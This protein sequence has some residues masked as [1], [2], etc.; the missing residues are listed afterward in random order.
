MLKARLP[1][2]SIKTLNELYLQKKENRNE[3]II[4]LKEHL[5]SREPKQIANESRAAFDEI[6]K[7]L[8]PS[9]KP[10]FFNKILA[11]NLESTK[12]DQEGNGREQ[13]ENKKGKF[14]TK[15]SR[16]IYNIRDTFVKK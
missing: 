9:A 7:F 1:K 5:K 10:I 8:L 3:Q 2:T 16:S 14:A 12:G 4:A 15:F 6:N 11:N 13:P